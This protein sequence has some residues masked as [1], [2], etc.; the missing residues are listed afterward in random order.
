MTLQAVR[1]LLPLIRLELSRWRG[2]G[3]A[4][5]TLGIM[6]PPKRRAAGC[7]LDRAPR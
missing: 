2:G 7:G 4:C 1:G 3:C 6:G 5:D